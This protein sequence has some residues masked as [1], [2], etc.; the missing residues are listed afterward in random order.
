MGMLMHHT[1]LNEQKKAAN[2][3]VAEPVTKKVTEE[4][5]EP[6]KPVKTA[7]RRKTSK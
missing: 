6:E 2:K 7:N 4:P 5:K 1:W 3:P